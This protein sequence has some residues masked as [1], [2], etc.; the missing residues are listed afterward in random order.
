[1]KPRSA[2]TQGLRIN[3]NSI[4]PSDVRVPLISL[5]W[6][7]PPSLHPPPLA[8]VILH[9]VVNLTLYASTASII[10]DTHDPDR[11]TLKI[12]PSR[13]DPVLKSSCEHERATGVQEG[14]L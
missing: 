5:P 1:M 13:E 10:L 11:V 8:S 9:R 2:A 4:S 3:S 12:L 7:S 14:L 6:P